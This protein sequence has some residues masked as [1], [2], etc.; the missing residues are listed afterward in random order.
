MGATTAPEPGYESAMAHRATCVSVDAQ[1]SDGTSQVT[2]SRA[3]RVPR[4]P[5]GH[6][7]E[8]V[9]PVTGFQRINNILLCDDVPVADLAAA[10][11]TP[12]YVYSASTIVSRYPAID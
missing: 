5:Q 4:R 8:S 7:L 2:H 11:G 10:E 12:L 9:I 6:G 3:T 1:V